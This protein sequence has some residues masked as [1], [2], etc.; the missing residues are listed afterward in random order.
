MF[1]LFLNRQRVGASF[2]DADQMRAFF[3]TILAI[4][5]FIGLLI[6]Y[7][8]GGSFAPSAKISTKRLESFMINLCLQ[9]SLVFL[10]QVTQSRSDKRAIEIKTEKLNVRLNLIRYLSHEIRTPLNTAFMGEK[11][12]SGA[13]DDIKAIILQAT[14]KV[15]PL[16]LDIVN[17]RKSSSNIT[18]FR[19]L[20]DDLLSLFDQSVSIA[21]GILEN[22]SLV[23]D[24]CNVALETLN[25]MLTFDKIDENMLVVEISDVD[26]LQLIHDSVKPFQ[27]NAKDAGVKLTIHNRTNIPE[28]TNA[29]FIIKADR[30]KINQVLRNLLSNGLKFTSANGRVD[31]VLLK[32]VNVILLVRLR[33][34]FV[35]RWQIRVLVFQ[36]RI[37]L[38]FSDNM[39]S[40]MPRRCSVAKDLA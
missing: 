9:I 15:K 22:S 38:S 32:K 13:A 7:G 21:N 12:I 11:L 3:D 33:I 1:L 6:A 25:D 27:I 2:K 5:F 23:E 16:L 26:P 34:S 4:L 17:L 8:I 37:N 31:V 24:S 40:L 35:S 10:L 39:C 20:F 18:N 19:K 14:N 36:K 29:G 30:F 28:E